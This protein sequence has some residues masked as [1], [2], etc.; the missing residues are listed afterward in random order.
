MWRKNKK[1]G[2]E[3]ILEWEES[4]EN[5][6]IEDCRSRN[7]GNLKILF[8]ILFYQQALVIQSE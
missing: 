1:L 7:R 5:E 8:L 6:L 3:Q 4:I 2:L